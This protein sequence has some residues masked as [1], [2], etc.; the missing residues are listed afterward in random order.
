MIRKEIKTYLKGFIIWTLIITL[1][2]VGVAI[3]YPHVIT[4]ETMKSM[5]E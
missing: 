3:L 5:D 2:Y 4:D 1:L